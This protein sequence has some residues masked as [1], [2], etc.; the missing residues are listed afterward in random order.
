M[1]NGKVK[2]HLNIDVRKEKENTNNENAIKTNIAFRPT[3]Y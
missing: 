3:E 1:K 2:F